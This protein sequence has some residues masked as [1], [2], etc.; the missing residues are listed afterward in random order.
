MQM[1]PEELRKI[2]AWEIRLMRDAAQG[3]TYAE[4][5]HRRGKTPKAIE[6]SFERLRDKLREWGGGSKAGLVHWVDTY[7]D[8]WLRA[9][10]LDEWT[11]L[12]RVKNP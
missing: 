9:I 6:K 10:G 11:Q 5:A 2:T 4:I 8:D 7:Y 1:P 12:R 3:L